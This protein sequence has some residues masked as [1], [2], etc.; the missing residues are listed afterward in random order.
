MTLPELL[1][2]KVVVK[3][4]SRNEFNEFSSLDCVFDDLKISFN[5][6]CTD[7]KF[8]AL[9]RRSGSSSKLSS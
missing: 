4:S 5:N 6:S 1:Y 8:V 2:A 9:L 3:L 7:N